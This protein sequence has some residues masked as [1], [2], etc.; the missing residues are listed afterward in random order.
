MTGGVSSET[1]YVVELVDY[2]GRGVLDATGQEIP[3]YGSY[4]ELE[5]YCLFVSAGDVLM[6]CREHGFSWAVGYR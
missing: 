3:P 5:V 4:V 2:L 6:G 1:Q